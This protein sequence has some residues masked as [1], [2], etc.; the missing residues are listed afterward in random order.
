MQNIQHI[1]H[2]KW[3]LTGEPGQAPLHNHSVCFENGII[4]DIL[5]T[6]KA[7]ELYQ[8]AREEHYQEHVVMPGLI[9]AH[10]HIGMNYF[11][12]LG[13]D[14]SLMD[15][16]HNHMFPAE[17]KWLSHE[18]VRDASLFAMAEMIRSGT[19]CF[20]DMFYFLQATAEATIE[21]GMR[22]CIGITVIE[23]PTGWAADTDEYF[24]K[25]LEFY[26]QYKDNPFITTTLAPH[27]PY[28]VSDKSFMRIKDLAESLNM[29]INVHLHETQDEINGSMQE[30]GKRPIRRLHDLGFL[31]P[32]VL[33]VHSV[34]LNAED[35]EILAQ[36]K[37]S[38]IHCP[39]S[40]MKL[41]SGACP[42]E[43]LRELGLNVALGTDSVASN[44]DLDMLSEMRSAALLAKLS[45]L[46][47][48]SLKATD[49]IGL[50]TLNGARAI[51]MEQQIGSLK[52]GKAADFI[53]IEMQDI[54]M[55]PV[56]EPESQIVYSSNRHQVS[57]VWV[58]GKQL[59]KSRKL[60]TLDEQALREKAMYWG[61][62][63]RG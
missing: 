38:I 36:V 44:N 34:N 57:D 49:V 8:A 58:N 33:S 17:K 26:E 32:D 22:S 9:N 6:A 41:A 20:N 12:G 25:G 55:L 24:S 3:V 40:N 14:R 1:V 29:K 52:A 11:R 7:R 15:W 27:A 16:L 39:E 19:T 42:V 10:T 28:T 56:Y 4:K 63:I 47:P 13:S 23:F 18:F 30:F 62:K 5:P 43:K 21:A 51:G 54:E 60:L 35:F 50:A 46:N 45:T 31:S 37:P 2:G 61:E 48:E 53:A 59:M